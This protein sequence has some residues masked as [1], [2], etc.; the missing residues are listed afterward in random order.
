MGYSRKTSNYHERITLF[1]P[2]YMISMVDLV[3]INV[4]TLRIDSGCSLVKEFTELIRTN[5]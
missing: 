3:A 4:E 2:T 5:P 1:D